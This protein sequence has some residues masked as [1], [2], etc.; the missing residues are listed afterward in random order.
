[1]SPRISPAMDWIIELSG[2]QHQKRF[3]DENDYLGEKY[4]LARLQY[5]TIMCLPIGKRLLDVQ[6][7]PEPMLCTRE[8]Q[9]CRSVM[10]AWWTTQNSA[11][12]S[13]VQINRDKLGRAGMKAEDLQS[14]L[15][16]CLDSFILYTEAD[17][18]RPQLFKLTLLQGYNAMLHP[19]N[20][21]KCNK[22]P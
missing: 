11:L 1:M 22:Y 14:H 5:P 9:L 2:K 13:R 21:E 10:S 7:S 20:Q 15:A 4:H 12:F 18:A 19:S 16:L 6:D 8:D 3:L 17:P